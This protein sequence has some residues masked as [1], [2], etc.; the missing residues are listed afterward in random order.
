MPFS[1][2]RKETIITATYE[3]VNNLVW[4]LQCTRHPVFIHQMKR[5]LSGPCNS[6]KTNDF[7]F[8]CLHPNCKMVP[9]CW[10]T[11]HG[12]VL[13]YETKILDRNFN[14]NSRNIIVSLDFLLFNVYFRYERCAK[15]L[16]TPRHPHRKLS[17]NTP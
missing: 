12:T 8:I 17:L 15:R 11:D 7:I 4:A 14:F 16:L 2:R 5:L 3:Y 10:T 9:C 1:L 6:N 13:F